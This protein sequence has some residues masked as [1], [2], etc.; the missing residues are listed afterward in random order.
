MKKLQLISLFWLLFVL[1]LL[2]LPPSNIPKSFWLIKRI[3]NFDKLVHLVI[4]ATTNFLI[5]VSKFN[6]LKNNHFKISLWVFLYS[7]FIEILQYL[8]TNDR[9][10]DILDIVANLLGI[11]IIWLTFEIKSGLIKK[12][13]ANKSLV[14][15]F[16]FSSLLAQSQDIPKPLTEF[17]GVWIAT[18]KNIDFPSTNNLSTESQKKELISLLTFHKS[19]GLNAI[20]LQIR[21]HLDAFYASKIEPW[22]EYLNGTQGKPP[23]PF[24]DPLE[25]A[26]SE[27]HKLGLELH[28][29]IN[30]YRATMSD[31]SSISANNLMNLHPE[32][33]IE[34]GDK[35]YLNPGLPE[36]WQYTEQVVQDIIERYDIDGL[37]MDDY[38]YPYRIPNKLFPD[39]ETYKK[40]NRGLG[41]DAWRRSNCDTIVKRVYCLIKS[42][43]KYIPFG[44]S[45]FGV[46]RNIDKDPKGSQTKAG[47][48][49]YDDLYADILKWEN[50]G[51]VDYLVPQLY[52]EKK[53]P[54][55]SFDALLPW[56]NTYCSK[57][58]LYIGIGIYRNVEK[59]KGWE[60][61]NELP[62]QIKDIRKFSTTQGLVFFSSKSLQKENMGWK[63]SLK[64]N[65]FKYPALIAPMNWFPE[66]FISEPEI[67]TKNSNI[68]IHFN[69]SAEIKRIIIIEQ[70]VTNENNIIKEIPFI[71]DQEINTQSFNPKNKY[72]LFLQG[73][74]NHLSKGVR[75]DK[76]RN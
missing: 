39:N 44:I 50:S 67:L 53:H 3:P 49:N 21:P 33:F 72:F 54:V 55:A 25:F 74:Y 65:Y 1:I 40:Y 17:R 26:I 15:F 66:I 19:L 62:E 2:L 28:A 24:Y 52:W 36:V 61:V 63:D 58:N 41:L 32:W 48:T 9:H 13:V 45:P 68:K 6:F 64:N 42:H 59:T 34:Y 31:K 75:I 38:F 69:G 8:L 23:L 27:A 30:P 5:I 20:F 51:W 11:V 35:K 70:T 37:H 57:R 71:Q 43:N 16:I 18:V 22:S 47:Q 76:I 60:S 12:K 56:W 29:W 4:F 10:F 73:R 46:W 7:I 14:V